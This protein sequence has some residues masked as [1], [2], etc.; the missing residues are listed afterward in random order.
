M[1]TNV[2]APYW[3]WTLAYSFHEGPNS[4]T[5]PRGYDRSRDAGFREKLAH[6]M[7]WRHSPPCLRVFPQAFVRRCSSLHPKKCKPQQI[8]LHLRFDCGFR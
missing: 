5:R 1:L 7:S 8:D 6:G 3:S 2:A 4:N